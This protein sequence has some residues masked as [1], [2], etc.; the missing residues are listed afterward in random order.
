MIYTKFLVK[1]NQFYRITKYWNERMR[2]FLIYQGKI[3]AAPKSKV[4]LTVEKLPSPMTLPKM[5][6]L[7]DRLAC[8]WGLVLLATEL[9]RL[10]E[11]SLLTE[12][13]EASDDAPSEAAGALIG[14]V[15]C[16]EGAFMGVDARFPLPTLEPIGSFCNTQTHNINTMIWTALFD[17]Q[18]HQTY[19]FTP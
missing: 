9:G 8:G 14:A 2:F 3:V 10:M 6:S 19:M 17:M 7:A 13:L 4:K 11:A 15:T 12:V 18:N 1:N 16:R 5:K